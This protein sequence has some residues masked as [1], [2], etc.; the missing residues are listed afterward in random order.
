LI[1]RE[2]TKTTPVGNGNSKGSSTSINKINR[3]EKG[4]VKANISTQIKGNDRKRWR[5][6]FLII[7]MS[8]RG[9]QG[10][11]VKMKSGVG[12]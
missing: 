3:N 5:I 4:K 12:E 6:T 9:W 8:G 7:F 2:N 11:Q 10:A 1:E